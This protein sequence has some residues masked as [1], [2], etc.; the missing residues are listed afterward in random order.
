M[1][2]RFF[3]KSRMLLFFLS[4]F[5]LFSPVRANWRAETV[6]KSISIGGK[7]INDVGKYSNIIVSYE[8]F[9]TGDVWIAC[10]IEHNQR[11]IVVNWCKNGLWWFPYDLGLDGR[12]YTPEDI[13]MTMLKGER[14]AISF[15]DRIQKALGLVKQSTKTGSFGPEIG[16]P[17]GT[18]CEGYYTT[19]GD[20]GKYTSI[21]RSGKTAK[22]SYYDRT[23]RNPKYA[24]FEVNGGNPILK[25]ITT[26][27]YAVNAGQYTSMCLASDK[28]PRVAYYDAAA[29]KLIYASYDGSSWNISS[30][31]SIGDLKNAGLA[32]SLKLDSN[33]NP[34]IAYYDG[35]DHSLKYISRDGSS[36]N[37]PVTVD[38]NADVG[39]YPS[40][41]LDL[42]DYPHI[43][44]YDATNFDLKYAQFNGTN[45]ETETVDSEND[46]GRFSSLSL[47]HNNY[48]YISYYDATNKDLKYAKWTDNEGYTIAQRI[49]CSQDASIPFFDS[50][51]ESHAQL[52][53]PASTFSLQGNR[54]TIE[55]SKRITFPP[56]GSEAD[57]Y[58]VAPTGICYE[59]NAFQTENATSMQPQNEAEF[60]FTSYY[61]ENAVGKEK[62]LAVF[63]YDSYSSR[64][65]KE[66]SS[67]FV[68]KNKVTASPLN[69]FGIFRIM[70]II[71][72]KKGIIKR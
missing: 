64:W 37:T 51:A 27:D 49:D 56:V 7:N 15:Y 25:S 24:E 22:V 50:T 26:I 39:R 19:G 6:L 60:T 54:V 43:S 67:V 14:P 8:T 53:L 3:S 1:S 65:I 42:Y 29:K 40:L 18:W 5:L 52:E 59:L 11:S 72:K 32:I 35:S 62:N 2:G 13:S 28:N 31:A 41:Q 70:E 63:R 44:Y 66:E 57:G 21:A 9:P 48:P 36:W 4:L 61:N 33:D 10:G 30:I 55:V 46:V 68:D 69:H 12:N 45:W 71:I 16:G 23:N 58:K 20:V 47:D 17:C 34:K 38:N